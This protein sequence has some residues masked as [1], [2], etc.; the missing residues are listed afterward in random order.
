MRIYE[1]CRVASRGQPPIGLVK[2]DIEGAEIGAVRGAG[3]MLRANGY[4]TM[5]AEI[6]GRCP[7]WFDATAEHPIAASG[8][9][10]LPPLTFAERQQLAHDEL[11]SASLLNR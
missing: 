6:N 5:I 7:R 2:L 8:A 4:P 9:H 10:L 11:Q 1:Q 3:T